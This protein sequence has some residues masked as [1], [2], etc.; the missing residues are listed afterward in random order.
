MGKE[1]RVFVRL[2]G[3]A[4]K[5][6]EDYSSATDRP[7]VQDGMIRTKTRLVTLYPAIKSYSFTGEPS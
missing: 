3:Q 5:T 1:E 7:I 6:I 4:E 2:W